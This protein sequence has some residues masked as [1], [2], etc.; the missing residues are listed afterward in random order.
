MAKSRIDRVLD[1]IK[2]EYGDVINPAAYYGNYDEDYVSTGLV[3]LD[4]V[5][6]GGFPCGRIT[7][8]YG[9]PHACKTTLGLYAIRNALDSGHNCV[10]IDLES[11]AATLSWIKAIGISE[12]YLAEDSKPVFLISQPGDGEEASEM[13]LELV[14][15][16]EIKVIVFDSVAAATPKFELDKALDK[17]VVASRARLMARTMRKLASALNKLKLKKRKLKR[18][19]ELPA[20]IFVNQEYQNISAIPWTNPHVSSGGDALKSYSSVRLRINPAKK[21]V[22]SKTKEVYARESK[23]VLIKSRVS[24]PYFEG[25]LRLYIA[26][27]N[28]YKEEGESYS[29][30][31][32]EF[33]KLLDLKIALCASKL[34]IPHSR[35]RL[36]FIKDGEEVIYDGI[37]KLVKDFGYEELVK[38]VKEATLF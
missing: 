31:R 17:Q 12:K 27:Y 37:E 9:P 8:L 33:D 5:L 25:I 21:M 16:G 11:G 10:F 28:C 15:S 1:K 20:M 7:E 29:F 19:V 38:K 24:K 6:G 2:E 35:D 26:D 14:A 23:W 18:N 32:G 4:Y 3:S 36:G 13:L 22:D 34:A 30:K